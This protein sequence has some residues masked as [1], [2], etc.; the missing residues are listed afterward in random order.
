MNLNQS[1]DTVLRARVA[2][3]SD[4]E[5]MELSDESLDRKGEISARFCFIP[6]S[7]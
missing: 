6:T 7:H 5:D 4:S 3:F 1:E 2:K